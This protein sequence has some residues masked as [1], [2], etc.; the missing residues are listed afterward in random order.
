MPLIFEVSLWVCVGFTSQFLPSS[1]TCFLALHCSLS[2][3]SHTGFSLSF[4][5]ILNSNL[6]Q[7]PCYTLLPCLEYSFSLSLLGNFFIFVQCQL[8]C[9]FCIEA[10]P[11]PHKRLRCI[12]C[13][14][15]TLK[16]PFSTYR[17]VINWIP[18]KYLFN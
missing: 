14:Y 18:S 1:P 2:V 12:V 15:G 7:G 17:S 8:I 6:P 4:S 11:M 10:F 3:S 13:F 5:N 9:H 16:S